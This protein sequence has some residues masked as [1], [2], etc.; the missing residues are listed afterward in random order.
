MKYG[1]G[2]AVLHETDIRYISSKSVQNVTKSEEACRKYKTKFT[3]ASLRKECLSKRRFS[4]NSQSLY[5]VSRNVPQSIP[6]HGQHEHNV[7]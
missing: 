7:Q 5:N 2:C 4:Q 1:F 3:P 6:K